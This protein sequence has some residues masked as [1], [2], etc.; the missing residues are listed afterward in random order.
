MRSQFRYFRPEEVPVIKPLLANFKRFRLP[1]DRCVDLPVKIVDRQ[2]K[3][4][5]TGPETMPE[6]RSRTRHPKLRQGA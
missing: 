4:W 5:R 1:V 6:C 3:S 2:T